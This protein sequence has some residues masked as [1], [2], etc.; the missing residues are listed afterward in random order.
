MRFGAHPSEL[1]SALREKENIWVHAV[2]VGE[3]LAVAPLIKNMK[4][5]F[6][7]ENIVLTTV[8]RT[9]YGLAKKSLVH[10]CIVL[11][12]P[13]DFSWV[14]NK[15]IDRIKP[16]IY[17]CMET[18]LWPNIFHS[19]FKYKVPIIL[20]NGRIS[21]RGFR[22][23][24]KIRFLTKKVLSYVTLLC[25]QTQ[26]DEERIIALGA[27]REKVRVVGNLKFDIITSLEHQP[28]EILDL[29]PDAIIFIAGS[30]HPGEE[31]ILLNVYAS[32][33]QKFNSLR[34]I[35]APRHV[36]RAV[37]IEKL[38]REKGFNPI[39]YTQLF[40]NKN[41]PDSVIIVDTIG[42]L[43]FLYS[44]ANVV[45]I[46]K[47]LC[48]GGGQNIIEPAVFAKPIIVG[49]RTE[50]FRE[51]VDDFKKEK[52]I[53]QVQNEEELL[54]VMEELFKDPQKLKE[55]GLKA[56]NLIETHQGATLRTLSVIQR[57][58]VKR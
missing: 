1:I 21:D 2:S 3:V 43:R 17:V 28:R 58:V 56:K 29:D 46:G 44:L 5:L 36:E 27:S 49:P 22:G 57:Y 31:E 55:I 18:E 30:T 53:I 33:K 8:T 40:K 19:L 13:I 9:G 6:P 15:F 35:I 25:M 39:F 51:I 24:R 52:A 42:Q 47:T 32:L 16:K 11:Y 26:A 10:E 45:F 54:K 38:V 41:S 34:L 48:V 12:A 23:Y 37:E 14:V 7:S 50:N 4:M 20:I